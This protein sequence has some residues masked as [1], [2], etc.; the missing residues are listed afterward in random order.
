MQKLFSYGTLQLQSVQ[1]DTFN[2]LLEGHADTLS[3]YKL[4]NL[5]ITDTE[6]IKSSAQNIHPI[7]QYSGNID[8]K[9]EGMIY[10]ITD[11][12]LA[13]CDKYEVKE[14]KRIKAI[15]DSG[16]EAWVYVDANDTN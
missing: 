1:L 9:I 6:V 3:K 2:R 11:K 15:F 10:Q 7:A 13:N 16:I 5:K 4:S 12:E 14:Y 8:D